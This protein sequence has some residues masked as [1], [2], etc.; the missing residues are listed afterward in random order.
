[1]EKRLSADN[2]CI[3]YMGFSFPDEN[4]DID[5]SESEDEVKPLT[6]SIEKLNE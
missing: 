3:N 1:M 2:I 6:L 5:S 4:R